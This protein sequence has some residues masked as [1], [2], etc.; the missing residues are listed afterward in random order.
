MG[1]GEPLRDIERMF[2]MAWEVGWFRQRVRKMEQ[3][4]ELQYLGKAR[5]EIDEAKAQAVAAL[6]QAIS[7]QDNAVVRVGSLIAI[8][9][10]GDIAV[11]TVSEVE[12]AELERHGDLL[13]DP[14]S[15][16]EYLRRLRQSGPSEL[17]S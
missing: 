3:A 17:D 14:I 2:L 5:A 4:V 8:K 13:R 6:L 9:S 1:W 7:T 16:L 15:A 12:A 11:W 10:E